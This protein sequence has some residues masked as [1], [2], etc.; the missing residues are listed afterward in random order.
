MRTFNY[1]YLPFMYYLIY[2]V[3]AFC[4]KR[5]YLIT[6]ILSQFSPPPPPQQTATLIYIVKP[7]F[8][9]L[10]GHTWIKVVMQF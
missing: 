9:R 2:V 5:I 3:L 7:P 8:S 10:L 6:I 1:P 4:K